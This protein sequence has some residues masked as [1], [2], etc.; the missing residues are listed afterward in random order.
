[1][2][3]SS[4]LFWFSLSPRWGWWAWIFVPGLSQHSCP[5]LQHL[6]LSVN[7]GSCKRVENSFPNGGRL[8]MVLQ[9]SLDPKTAIS[10]HSTSIQIFSFF[11]CSEITRGLYLYL[12]S[13]RVCCSCFQGKRHLLS[14][15]QGVGWRIR[16]I[17]SCLSRSITH[18]SPSAQQKEPFSISPLAF[19]LSHSMKW[20]IYRKGFCKCM[21]PWPPTQ[22]TL[23]ELLC[24]HCSFSVLINWLCL[25]RLAL[26][27]Q[28]AR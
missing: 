19:N 3:E 1:M 9:Q 26:S 20:K 8:V 21:Q 27:R 12:G 11:I 4:L 10:P 23:C 16:H 6:H 15:L 28:Q 7:N 13:G 25:D 2:V 17:A 24:L 18:H 22:P 5:F 14:M